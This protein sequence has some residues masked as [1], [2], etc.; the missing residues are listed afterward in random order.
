MIVLY[1]WQNFFRISWLQLMRIN[2]SEFVLSNLKAYRWKPRFF[3]ILIKSS[4]TGV[5][6]FLQQFQKK[7]SKL[8]WDKL[9]G[10]L[11][12]EFFLQILQP[13][14]VPTNYRQTCRSSKNVLIYLKTY[15]KYFLYRCA[16][17]IWR[18]R[19]KLI[20]CVKI[21]MKVNVMNVNTPL[22]SHQQQYPILLNQSYH[23]AVRLPM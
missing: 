3:L 5:C 9:T 15:C 13:F 8:L 18:L 7:N 19:C 6:I 20:F 17:C 11:P 1:C 10:D 14:R 23:L 2:L 12:I 16:M 21:E 4:V 22:L